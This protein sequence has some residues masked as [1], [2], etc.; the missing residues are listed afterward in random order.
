MEEL[1][2]IFTDAG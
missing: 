1:V 2:K